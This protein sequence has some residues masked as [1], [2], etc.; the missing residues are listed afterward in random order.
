MKH[1]ILLT[2]IILLSSLLSQAQEKQTWTL[3]D[4][5]D[6]ALEKNIQLQKDRISLQESEIDVQSS[7]ADLFPSISFSTDH[8]IIN[9][10]F[11]ESSSVISGNEV[12]NSNNK[13]T[14]NGSYGLNAQWTIFNGG[15]KIY[16]IKQ[17]KVNRNIAEL[18]VEET[19][20]LL[21]EDIT[22]MFIQILYS[23]EAVEICKMT[24]EVSEATYKRGVELYNEG[25]ISKADLTQL[26][27]QVANDKY[28]K[29][30]AESSL[31]N[32]KLQLKQLL[33]ID[34]PVEMTLARPDIDDAGIIAVLPEQKDIYEAALDQRPEIKSTILNTEYSRL[35]LSSA[36]S[37][38]YPTI[39]LTAST[40]ANTNNSSSDSWAQQ[41]K[42]GWSNMAGISLSIPIFDNLQTQ[43]NVKKAKLQYNTSLL[44]QTDKK[45]ELYKTIETLWLDALN[46]QEEYLAACTK[47][48]S[49]QTSYEM[50]SEQFNLGM[51]NTLELLTEK[52]NLYSARQQKLQSK[53]M[54]LLNRTLLDFYSGTEINL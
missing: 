41:M 53:Y 29:V 1:K 14:Y 48:E 47:L 37:G 19:I 28:Q 30:S 46:A 43:S 51:K 21:K 45:K 54:A 6:Y 34:E 32:Y 27:A 9:R 17:Q 44:D 36:K 42:Y 3:Q 16:N 18:S 12:I 8:N 50:V 35:A 2:A 7:I 20:N 23:E 31:R 39:N 11:Q 24:L 38:Y 40:Y 49:C 25:S 26:E 52:N 22:K 33:E 15:K 4:C 13:T 10:P 5:I